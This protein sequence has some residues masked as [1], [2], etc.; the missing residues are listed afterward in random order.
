MHMLQII[1][2]TVFKYTYMQTY[3]NMHDLTYVQCYTHS[4]TWH[5]K[6][7]THTSPQTPSLFRQC[8]SVCENLKYNTEG[9]R[10]EERGEEGWRNEE[11]GRGGGAN[12]PEWINQMFWYVTDALL[13]LPR[14]NMD[15]LSLCQP[16]LPSSSSSSSSLS[17]CQWQVCTFLCTVLCVCVHVCVGKA[18][19]V[20]ACMNVLVNI[21][22][23]CGERR[24][25]G[26]R[27]VSTPTLSAINSFKLW[28]TLKLR[29]ISLI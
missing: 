27:R 29:R 11:E 5:P 22:S 15:A 28:M 17:F 21:F 12:I 7:H 23:V 13:S 20:A 26:G 24:V 18:L 9:R 25:C 6:P 14:G 19:W 16:G 8:R 1:E 10:G 3:V 2:G 4:P